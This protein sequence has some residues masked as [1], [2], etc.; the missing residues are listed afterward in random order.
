MQQSKTN[1]YLTALLITTTLFTSYA[2]AIT[3]NIDQTGVDT[4]AGDRMGSSV[5]ISGSN[6]IVGAPFNDTQSRDSGAAYIFDG[7]GNQAVLYAFDAGENDQFGTSVAI[8]RDTAVVGSLLKDTSKEGKVEKL[9]EDGNPVFDADGNQVF[10]DGSID[11][12]DSGAIYIFTS[13]GGNWFQQGWMNVTDIQQG[14]WFG[15][16]V[17]VKDNHIAVG[18]PLRET[19]ESIR[20]AGAVLVFSRY[21]SIWVDEDN[22]TSDNVQVNLLQP[23]DLKAGDWFG[24]SVSMS[25]NTIVVGADGSDIDGPS[26]GAVYVFTRNE[27]GSWQQQARLRPSDA[28]S[29]QF[30]GH[31][32]SISGNTI[33]AGAYQADSGK[34]SAYVF[35]R[36]ADGRWTEQTMLTD[37]SLTVDDNFASSVA[38]SGSL[39]LVGSYRQDVNGKRSG[40]AYLYHQDINDTWSQVDTIDST[41]SS[42]D[43]F[44]FSLALSGYSS[45][46]GVPG[47]NSTTAGSVKVATGLDTSVDTD[48]DGTNNAVDTD[49][50]NDG[51][52][53]LNDAFATIDDES[54]DIDNDGFGDNSDAFIFNSTE[55]FDTD[56]DGLGN[57]LDTD[58]D[59]DG[60]SDIEEIVSG[61]DPLDAS[62]TSSGGSTTTTTDNTTT[63]DTTTGDTTTEDN[64]VTS[65]GGDS[66]SFGVGF[67]IFLLLSSLLKRVRFI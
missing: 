53:D 23:A 24:S 65:G 59:N 26:S 38:V 62:S 61:S 17:A 44:S 52:P 11:V 13:I 10:T 1:S 47:I 36:T 33:I 6:F 51:V 2:F 66:G 4:A 32:V 48:V 67:L 41:A 35:K 31:S 55:S 9:D 19:G 18:S 42:Y 21:G 12:A 30:F 25:S 14:D 22:L 56:N 37:A 64:V 8:D 39:A 3:P 60:V 20:D 54:S 15:Y 40:I 16:S 49:D 29:F 28:G 7:V 5:A 50:D 34:G 57:N 45:A 46:I 27:D 43:D 58:D 63:G